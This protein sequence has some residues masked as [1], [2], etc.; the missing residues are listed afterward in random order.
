MENN[1][2]SSKKLKLEPSQDSAIPPLCVC[3]KEMKCGPQ[4]DTHTPMFVAVLQ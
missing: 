4:K 1:G 3:P 2:G